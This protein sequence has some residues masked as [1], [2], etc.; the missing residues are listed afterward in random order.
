MTPVWGAKNRG[1]DVHDWF[2]LQSMRAINPWALLSAATGWLGTV[3][4]SPVRGRPH[5]HTLFACS[6]A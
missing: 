4:S 2:M 6:F 5:L 3:G 1:S